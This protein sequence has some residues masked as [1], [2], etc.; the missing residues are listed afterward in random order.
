MLIDKADWKLLREKLKEIS[1]D[2]RKM[3]M[4]W[5]EDY[6]DREIAQ[7]MEYKSPDVAKTSRLRCLDRLKRLYK[8]V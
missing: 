5:A 6:S 8:T 4:L 2:C 7:V 1:E 3:L